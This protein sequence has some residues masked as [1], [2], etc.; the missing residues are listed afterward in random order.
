MVR[1][2]STLTSAVL[3]DGDVADHAEVDDAG[4]QL[5]VDDGL[6]H[7]PDLFGGGAISVHGSQH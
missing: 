6:E 7:A 4:V 2:I 3:V 1:A 5:G